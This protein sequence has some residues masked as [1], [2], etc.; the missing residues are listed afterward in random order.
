MANRQSTHCS[1]SLQSKASKKTMESLT[2]LQTQGRSVLGSETLS[3]ITCQS[4]S[5]PPT[6]SSGSLT[7]LIEASKRPIS[8]A[9]LSKEKQLTPSIVANWMASTAMLQW[10]NLQTYSKGVSVAMSLSTSVTPSSTVL[11]RW[12]TRKMFESTNTR[13]AVSEEAS[14]HPWNWTAASPTLSSNTTHQSSKCVAKWISPCYT[15]ITSASRVSRGVCLR[16][17]TYKVAQTNKLSTNIQSFNVASLQWM[18]CLG[19]K[20]PPHLSFS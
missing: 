8:T 14:A 20:R 2:S 4:C 16:L 1:R 19:M 7:S 17:I 11:T 5:K 13:A 6:S 18:R 15:I 10:N 9:F 12:T 3:S